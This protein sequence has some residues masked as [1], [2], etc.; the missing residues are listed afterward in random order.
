MG[1]GKTILFKLETEEKPVGKKKA[2]QGK[3]SRSV[4]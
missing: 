2:T 4:Y 3:N 1:I